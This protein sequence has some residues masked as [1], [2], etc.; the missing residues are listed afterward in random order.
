MAA[1]VPEEELDKIVD[2][3]T[4]QGAPP[5]A[6]LRASAG[7]LGRAC[8]F[9]AGTLV[10]REVLMSVAP[11]ERDRNIREL[12]LTAQFVSSRGSSS[13]GSA[14]VITKKD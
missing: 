13:L 10:R 14:V 5:I 9:A 8:C 1:A 4:I 2:A 3:W 12:E 7:L 11:A 6:L